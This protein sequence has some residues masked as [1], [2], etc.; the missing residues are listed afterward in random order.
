VPPTPRKPLF[1]MLMMV[2]MT[3]AN[4]HASFR[5]RLWRPESLRQFTIHVTASTPTRV[6]A[7]AHSPAMI[8]PSVGRCRLPDIRISAPYGRLC[9]NALVPH[10]LTAHSHRMCH[11]A[12]SRLFH[13]QMRLFLRGQAIRTPT[14]LIWRTYEITRHHLSESFSVDQFIGQDLGA[15]NFGGPGQ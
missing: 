12:D 3:T 2:G 14:P 4:G 1:V 7:T 13:I 11:R 9:R 15:T 5:P 10:L 8:P 6:K